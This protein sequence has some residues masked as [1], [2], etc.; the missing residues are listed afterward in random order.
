MFFSVNLLVQSLEIFVEAH[1]GNLLV[2]SAPLPT[3]APQ[4]LHL[5][6]GQLAHPSQ[7]EELQPF[8]GLISL[9][10]IAPGL[11]LTQHQDPLEALRW[12]SSPGLAL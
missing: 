12:G 9:R 5:W 10:P 6:Q 8:K 1:S 4:A 2:G 7:L 11:T 3:Q